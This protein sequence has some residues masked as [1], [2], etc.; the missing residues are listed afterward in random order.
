MPDGRWRYVSKT[1][2]EESAAPERTR[3]Q[4]CGQLSVRIDGAELAGALRGRQVPLLLAYLV[5]ARDRH[6]GREELSL[7]LW[8]EQAPRAQDAALRTLLSRPPPAP[9]AAALPRREPVMLAPP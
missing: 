4:L 2:Q 6:I 9:G 3:I 5:L 7:A 8:P 1:L